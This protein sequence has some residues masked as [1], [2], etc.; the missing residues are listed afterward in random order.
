MSIL[1][2]SF[3]SCFKNPKVELFNI[4]TKKSIII[5]LNSNEFTFDDEL[6]NRVVF[7]DNNHKTNMMPLNKLCRNFI[8]DEEKNVGILKPITPHGKLEYFILVDKE[9]LSYLEKPQKAIYV[10]T[11]S[12]YTPDKEYPLLYSFDGQS[13]FDELL[14]DL[15][16]PKYGSFKMENIM[17]TCSLNNVFESIIVGIDNGDIYRDKELTMDHK[18]FGE[19]DKTLDESANFE[20]GHL[21]ELIKFILMTVKPF[22]Y[23]NYSITFDLNKIGITGA[24]SGGLASFYAGMLFPL[25]FGYV[26]SFS[27]A[28]GLFTLNS[29]KKFIDENVKGKLPRLYFYCGYDLKNEKDLETTLYTRM[30][31]VIKLVKEKYQRKN[32]KEA[33]MPKGIHHES[34]WA[35]YFTE[36]YLF[37]IND[38]GEKKYV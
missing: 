9:N 34:I 4:D 14:G 19:L 20:D 30:L 27:P 28:I 10:Y 38:R 2:A 23:K 17:N 12:G 29:W 18:I 21:D 37:G 31:P 16:K 32:L 8:Y 26:L 22:I 15:Q 35:L 13:L 7:Y 5:E 24:S 6:Y 36:G 1:S 3:K 11:P 33:Y 25:E